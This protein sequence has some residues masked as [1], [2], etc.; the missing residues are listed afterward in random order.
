MKSKL[1]ATVLALSASLIVRAAEVTVALERITVA[2]DQRGFVQQPSGRAF[3]PWG[4]NYGN[5]GRLMEDFWEQEWNVL[6]TDFAKMKRLGVGVVRVHLQFGKFM[7]SAESADDSALVRLKKLV[8]LAER[9]GLYL[10]LTGLGCYRTS[11]VPAW[12][13]ALNEKERWAAQC[14]FWRAVAST[15]Q[16]SNAVFCYDLMN[17]PMV[18]GGPDEKWYSGKLLGEY[19]FLQ[20]I[21]RDL[22]G[23]KRTDLAGQWIDTLTAAI[24]E[25]DKDHLITVGML[26]WVEGWGHLFGFI[27]KDVAP[28]V[29][30]LSIHL[31]P[32]SKKP[33]NVRKALSECAGHGKPVVIEETFPLSCTPGELEAFLKESR[34]IARGWVWHYD[35]F[36]PEEYDARAAQGKRTLQ[37]TVWQAA[38]RLFMKMKPE[39][40]GDVE[41]KREG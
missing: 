10:D 9:T 16:A 7:K 29:D 33:A 35:G 19:D 20:R 26:P 2:A 27:P 41:K 12:Y 30:F 28:H 31:Y 1:L 37:D 40:V 38:L 3:I 8:G 34:S 4:V 23:R 13:D 36:T 6:E 24:R 21:S 32:E 18:P 25:T 14:V 5:A 22:A 17:E 15:C 39:M 11:D